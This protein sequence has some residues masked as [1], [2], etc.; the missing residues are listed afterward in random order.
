MFTQCLSQEPSL[1]LK[2][3]NKFGKKSSSATELSNF[4]SY[5]RVA[6][7]TGKENPTIWP[8]NTA[9]QPW[10]FTVLASISSFFYQSKPKIFFPMCS[11]SNDELLTP[12]PF[13]LF[14]NRFWKIVVWLKEL[15]YKNAMGLFCC[16]NTT[17]IPLPQ[18][19]HSV[20]FISNIIGN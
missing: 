20:A 7:A 19:S 15:Y 14:S 6:L 8:S 11:V 4:L 16:I 13:T 1:G 10:Q 5:E 18:A 9:G 17:P 3:I 12:M 2:E